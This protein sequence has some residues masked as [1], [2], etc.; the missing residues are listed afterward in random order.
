MDIKTN[1]L[2]LTTLL[3]ASSFAL[4]VSN[5]LVCLIGK[6]NGWSI[7]IY[8][9]VFFAQS[10]FIGIFQFAKTLSLKDFST[11]GFKIYE[12][13]VP[14]SK[15]SQLQNSVFFLFHFGFYLMFYFFILLF[16]F[17]LTPKF[18]SAILLA[19]GIFFCNHAFSFIVNFERD[20]ERRLNLG[21][22]ITIPYIRV[23]PINF[24]M[25]LAFFLYDK[26][27]LIIGL[28]ILIDLLLHIFEHKVSISKE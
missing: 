27:I 23:I 20:R 5:I 1:I 25:L 21:L 9:L 17:K 18:D 14:I 28:K 22:L 6:S 15:N 8:V 2:K 24:I 13:S 10:I 3:S 4:I 26:A 7:E 19:M 12:Y 16:L 11:K